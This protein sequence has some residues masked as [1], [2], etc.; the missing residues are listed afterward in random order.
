VRRYIKAAVAK[1]TK[2]SGGASSLRY[3]EPA[4]IA[5]ATAA[6]RG[7]T[8]TGVKAAVA[9]ALDSWR[10]DKT[11]AEEQLQT[12]ASAKLGRQLTAATELGALA[13]DV[14][15]ATRLASAGKQ[16]DGAGAALEAAARNALRPLVLQAGLVLVSAVPR[17]RVAVYAEVITK[18]A[19]TKPPD[20]GAAAA[21]AA[22]AEDAAAVAS[23]VEPASHTLIALDARAKDLGLPPF[24]QVVLVK[25]HVRATE[26]LLRDVN[27]NDTSL[28]AAV[29]S[30]VEE[31]AKD[32]EIKAAGDALMR[33]ADETPAGKTWMASLK[34][35]GQW[36]STVERVA[37]AA[38]NGVMTP[39]AAARYGRPD[40]L[41]HFSAKPEPVFVAD[42]LP[43]TLPSVAHT[44][45][46]TLSRKVNEWPGPA[47]R[48]ALPSVQQHTWWGMTDNARHVIACHLT[49]H[50]RV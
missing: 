42:R 49:Q 22:A 39:D 30:T 27:V 41:V 23:A 8:V 19:S 15:K 31:H 21:H 12:M 44:K 16:P 46:V 48:A 13:I 10:H 9:S 24:L 26:L 4:L 37:A 36:S 45:C 32:A 47:A 43:V 20:A 35:T 14:V 33:V 25:L 7:G 18:L 29:E 50:T 3:V 34:K 2:A 40:T 5:E 11:R 28:A 38:Q 17:D 1:A 6:L